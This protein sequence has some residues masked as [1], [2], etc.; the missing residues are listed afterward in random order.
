MAAVRPTPGRQSSC[1][2]LKN[3]LRALHHVCSSRSRIELVR[4]PCLWAA[5]FLAWPLIGAHK[6]EKPVAASASFFVRFL[7]EFLFPGLSHRYSIM[8]RI[9]TGSS[10]AIAVTTVTS[11]EYIGPSDRLVL[12]VAHV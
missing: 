12:V 3:A 8:T 7:L 11:L 1:L 6:L 4:G 10:N 5:F 9:T 2:E